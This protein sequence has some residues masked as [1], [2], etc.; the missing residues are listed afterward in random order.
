M[1]RR[2]KKLTALFMTGIMMCSVA[3]C[4]SASSETSGSAKETKNQETDNQEADSKEIQETNAEN[5]S[6]K[7]E[8][9]TILHMYTDEGV[10]Q[11]DM[12]SVAMRK[13]VDN[14]RAAHPEIEVVEEIVGQEAG[15]E[16]KI[17]TLA[18]A[19]ELPDIFLALPSMMES[20]Y[21]NGQVKDLKPILDADAEWKDRF[22][23][24]SFGDYTF[25]DKILG[26]PRCAIANHVLYWNTDIFKKCGIDKF[27]ANSEEFKEAVGKLKENGYTPLSSGNKGK[28]AIASQVM[29]GLLFKFVDDTWYDSIKNY[30]GASFTDP[31][32]VEAITYLDDL[33][34][35]GL[36]NDDVNS[37]DPIQ[38]RPQFYNEKAAMYIEGS[39]SVSN[40]INEAPQEIIDKTDIAIFPPVK[41]KEDLENQIVGGQGWGFSLNENLSEEKTKLAVDLLKQ[42]SSDEIQTMLAEGGS[43]SILKDVKYD[44]TKLNPFYKE[45][46]EM[47]K[48]HSKVVGCPEVQLSTTYM[49]AS[50]TGYQEMSIGSVTP[51]ELAERLQEAHDS[52][53]KE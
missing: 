19:N 39:W 14:Y 8:K 27:P 50:Y 52:N 43:L 21:E 7:K 28:Y 41:G 44:E 38:A 53:K 4:S 22:A 2:G 18:A 34:K 25:G 29:P 20:F 5:G 1:R 16:T 36:F 6:D 46:L 32:V 11:G 35:M 47:Y 31:E 42:I 12:E 24:G 40:F 37:I 17:K 3:G 26:N 10:A 23:D 45:F 48:S 49:D 30:K 9:I 15:Y 51:Q 33:M 13:A